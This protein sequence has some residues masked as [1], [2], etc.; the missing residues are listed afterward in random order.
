[1][2]QPP[3]SSLDVFIS[4][5]PADADLAHQLNDALQMQGKT[6]WFD[7]EYIPQ[8]AD[9]QQEI[10]QGIKTFDNI[11]FLLSPHK[12]LQK[13]DWLKKDSRLRAAIA[14]SLFN[15]LYWAKEQN[16]LEG[17]T[18]GVRSV[19]FSPKGELIATAS[20]DGYGSE[21]GFGWQL[22][23]IV[24]AQFV[25]LP[26]DEFFKHNRQLLVGMM[27]TFATVLAVLIL[28]IKLWLK[29]IRQRYVK[30]L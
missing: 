21:N 23:E 20:A 7:Q 2:Q 11:L 9:V 25:Y 18:E 13:V 12:E 1:M 29:Q 19:N 22:N 30:N 6:T 3:A 10:Y 4:Y 17:H 26:V 27:A 14:T 16:Q 15:S 24:G 5:S 8:D 28:A